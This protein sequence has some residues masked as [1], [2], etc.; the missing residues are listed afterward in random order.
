MLKDLWRSITGAPPTPQPA[1]V[2][3][4]D[5]PSNSEPPPTDDSDEIIESPRSPPPIQC[6][7]AITTRPS[8]PEPSRS[9]QPDGD[10]DF[11]SPHPPPIRSHLEFRYPPPDY[12]PPPDS[13]PRSVR[14]Q[15]DPP[16]K[17]DHSDSRLFLSNLQPSPPSF[18]FPEFFEPV[19]V[20]ERQ[21]L[22]DQTLGSVRP[23]AISTPKKQNY[24][25][26]QPKSFV[27]PRL[28]DGGG[29]PFQK[30]PIPAK[31]PHLEKKEL[32]TDEF[33]EEPRRPRRQRFF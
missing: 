15:W 23:S 27:T 17:D 26:S 25:R 18:E 1:P 16:A 14:F 22:I 30:K 7:L 31:P 20:G 5:V 12:P 21:H 19:D 33:A 28:T 11:E 13:Q 10:S 32:S 24:Q 29:S 6:H 8:Q 3:S 4:E 9:F 2:I